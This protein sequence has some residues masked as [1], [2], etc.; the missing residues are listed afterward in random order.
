MNRRYVRHF[1]LFGKSGQYALLD[2]KVLVIGAGGLGCFVL[3]NLAAAGIG[4]ISVIDFDRISA[5]NLNRQILYDL[6]LIHI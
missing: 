5:S 2:S 3:Y 6:S 1:S 4:K